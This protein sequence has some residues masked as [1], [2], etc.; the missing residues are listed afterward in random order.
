MNVSFHF[1]EVRPTAEELQELAGEL[2]N[3]N[4]HNFT[5][6]SVFYFGVTASKTANYNFHVQKDNDNILLVAFI[7]E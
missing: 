4:W 2:N 7:G 6:G 5:N 1:G 3:V